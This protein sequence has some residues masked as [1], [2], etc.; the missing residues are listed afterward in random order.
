M[1]AKQ[2][3]IIDIDHIARLARLPISDE[4]KKLF[5][6]QLAAIISYVT[7]L[8]EIST[9]GILPTNQVTG[10]INIFREDTVDISRMLTQKEALANAP[11]TFNGFVKVKAIFEK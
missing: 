1:R 5:I 3:I 4:E 2:N 11:E 9:E 10:L 7:K 8:N 6:P